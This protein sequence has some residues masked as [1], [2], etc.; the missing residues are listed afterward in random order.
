[1]A[2][3]F[4]YQLQTTYH[5]FKF[6]RNDFDGHGSNRKPGLHRLP[7]LLCHGSYP[8]QSNKKGD[9]F[10]KISPFCGCR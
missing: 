9:I 1:M 6:L 2:P 5:A 8:S 3:F 4:S 10:F 7:F